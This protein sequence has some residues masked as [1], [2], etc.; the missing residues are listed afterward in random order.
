M[1]IIKR[2]VTSVMPAFLIVSAVACSKP[3]TK[4][5]PPAETTNNQQTIPEDYDGAVLEIKVNLGKVNTFSSDRP[6]DEN[7]EDIS[8]I[9]VLGQSNFTYMSGYKWEYGS[10]VSSGRPVN[11]IPEAPTLP[12]PDTVFSA[13]A[14]ADTIVKNSEVSFAGLTKAH[15]MNI[16]SNSVRTTSTLGGVTPSFGTRW[17]ELTGTKVVFVQAAVEG[18]GM[19]EWVKDESFACNS[20]FYSQHLGRKL[21]LYADA[22]KSF[23]TVY[24]SLKDSYN[25]VYS[26]YIW[27][28]GEQDEQVKNGCPI[29]DEKTYFAAFKS[30][31]EDLM[32]DL[33]LDF[34]GI[35]MLR[36]HYTG[37]AVYQSNAYTRARA[38]QYMAVNEIDNLYMLSTISETCDV[39]SPDMMADGNVHYSQKTFN[40]MGKEM[41]DNLYSV[42]GLSDSANKYSGV[43]VSAK[44]GKVVL[45]TNADGETT[46]GANIINKRI[47]SDRIQVAY[48]TLGNNTTHSFVFK[49]GDTDLS[50]Y[51]D[52]YGVIDW[53]GLSKIGITEAYI[54][55]KTD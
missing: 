52:E 12:K 33:D 25:I 19:C 47:V 39:N 48:N 49:K 28:Q 27:N 30:M 43:R 45:R 29:V 13:L 6:H 51:I 18:T 31:H 20:H 11:R 22:V 54:I 15:D 41:A 53:S 17:H 5:T 23:K 55:V 38:G 4:N 34:G 44:G 10:W 21:P 50:E 35:S 3:S 9:L 36:S 37:S 46:E 40:K 2:V 32:K 8:I 26:G 7:K 1:K 16:L 24:D 42:L 14:G